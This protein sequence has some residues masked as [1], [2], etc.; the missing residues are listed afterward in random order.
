MYMVDYEITGDDHLSL[1]L[2]VTWINCI[3]MNDKWSTNKSNLDLI[4]SIH[5]KEHV[6]KLYN[7]RSATYVG[8][9]MYLIQVT[10][11]V[12]LY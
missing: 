7:W 11:Q 8:R 3:V 10:S 6:N 5:L 1:Y 2:I 9:I 4:K 12:L